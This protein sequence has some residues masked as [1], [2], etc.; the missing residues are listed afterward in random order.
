MDQVRKQKLRETLIFRL[1]FRFPIFGSPVLEMMEWRLK[2]PNVSVHL[3][4][5]LAQVV[6]L[7]P[8]FGAG[9]VNL[10]CHH[11]IFSKIRIMSRSG[12]SSIHPII[13]GNA[14]QI[15]NIA[16]GKEMQTEILVKFHMVVQ[17][18]NC[19]FQTIISVEEVIQ[20]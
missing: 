5:S 1:I 9:I 14:L 6:F 15:H 20:V 3:Q 13:W 17:G 4:I 16:K 2:D 19:E 18:S 10:C 8:S 7:E 12:H 11:I